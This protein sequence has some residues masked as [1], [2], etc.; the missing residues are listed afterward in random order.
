MVSEDPDS[1]PLPSPP[2]SCLGCPSAS[3]GDLKLKHMESTKLQ[4]ESVSKANVYDT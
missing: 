2:V 4:G 1:S 3:L